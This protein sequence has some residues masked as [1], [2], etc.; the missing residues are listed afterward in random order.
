MCSI[1]QKKSCL[2][3]EGDRASLRACKDNLLKLLGQGEEGT[4]Q[5]QLMEIFLPVLGKSSSLGV[6]NVLRVEI[7][8]TGQFQPPKP[9]PL[10]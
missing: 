3:P 7:D 2:F 6:T 8:Q 5:Q 9:L 4:L 1:T 10:T